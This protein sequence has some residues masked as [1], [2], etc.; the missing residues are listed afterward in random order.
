MKDYQSMLECALVRAEA[1][2]D[3]SRYKKIKD[4]LKKVEE[5]ILAKEVLDILEEEI[6]RNVYGDKA[7]EWKQTETDSYSFI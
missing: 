5:E 7:D 4:D 6:D 1:D 3:I 2:E